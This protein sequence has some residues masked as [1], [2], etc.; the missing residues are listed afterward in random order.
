MKY[1][2]KPL[3][4]AT[5]AS[6]LL[7]SCGGS[8]TET[9]TTTTSAVKEAV[10]MPVFNAD[11][12]FAYVVRQ[13][14]FGPRVTNSPANVACAA[15]LETTLKRFSQHVVVQPF[16]ARAFNGTVL[17]GRNIIASFNPDAKV[18]I[19][20]CSHWDS[21]PWADHDP[22]PANYNTPIPGAN[23]GASGV[24]VLLELARIMALQ[25]PSAGVD[26]V[27]FDAEDYGPTKDKQDR[28]SED[29]WGLGSQYW[30]RN[31]HIPGYKARFGILLDMVGV[32]NATFMQEGISL[33]YAPH[34][35]K[36]V[37]AIAGQA[38][39]GSFF[40]D[41]EG[42][43]ITDDHYY[44]NRDANIPTINIIHLQREGSSTG[45][46]PYWHTIHDDLSKVNPASL[47]AVGDVLVHVVY[48]E[49]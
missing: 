35:V 43:S 49:K 21:R 3:L 42:G 2:L 4:L 45:F 9:N 7:Y 32:E 18:R 28:Y 14:D 39:Y 23:D 25:P 41:E 27:L 24:G 29:E 16:K 46:Y 31:P 44:I 5:A 30:A 38:G 12:A 22:D 48:L 13:I 15:W 6:I 1:Y 36:K 37:W 17:S 10:A 33:Y 40:V 19:L 8:G 20:L 34:I 47:Q 11:S 26:I